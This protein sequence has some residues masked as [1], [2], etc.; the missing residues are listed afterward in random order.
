MTLIGAA[1]QALAQ[2]SSPGLEYRWLTLWDSDYALTLSANPESKAA[3]ATLRNMLS[4][5]FLTLD[6]RDVRQEGQP[7]FSNVSR[8]D[9]EF[10]LPQAFRRP[11]QLRL[12]F[13]FRF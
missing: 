10:G 11:Q 1:S 12:A 5:T 7:D 9:P 3:D 6:S 8:P 4:R 2:E 13:H